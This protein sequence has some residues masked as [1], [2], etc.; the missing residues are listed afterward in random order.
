MDSEL[1]KEKI[2]RYVQN[3]EVD[4]WIN[5]LYKK[6][7]TFELEFE[8]NYLKFK[9]RIPMS[10]AFEISKIKGQDNQLYAM[11]NV[12]SLQPKLSVNQAKKLPQDL[13]TKLKDIFEEI[14]P[15]DGIKK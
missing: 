13:L 1:N 11:I 4:E 14:F 2:K 15:K 12:L 3:D 6:N 7:A 9:K 8:G 10:L 5:S